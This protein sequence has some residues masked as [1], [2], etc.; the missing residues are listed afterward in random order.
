MTQ[1]CRLDKVV[2]FSTQRNITYKRMKK[3]SLMLHIE[4]DNHC[5]N[6]AKLCGDRL[7]PKAF[8]QDSVLDQEGNLE[9][10]PKESQN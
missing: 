9:R 8:I 10:G 1:G 2:A 7:N 4:N 6:Q 3:M 5:A